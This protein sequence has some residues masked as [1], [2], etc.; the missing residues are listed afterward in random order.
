MNYSRF[1]RF[2]RLNS[3]PVPPAR[4]TVDD[5]QPI[6]E[7]TA[8]LFSLIIFQW[9]TP[10]L[11]LGYNRPLEASDLYELQDHRKSAYIGAKILASFERREKE[12]RKYNEALEKGEISPGWRALWW[13][14]RGNKAQ[15]L[16][17]WRE[18]DGKKR[19]SLTLAM[20][21][22]VKFFFWSAGFFKVLG[23]TA[24]IT[25]PLLVKV[26]DSLNSFLT[27]YLSFS[28]GNRQFCYRV[29]RQ[30]SNGTTYP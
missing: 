25:S 3:K 14:L 26:S 13:T 27:S 30:S 19:A 8:S 24:Q 6:P 16:K 7:T 28:I 23:D 22:S 15:R 21:D 12:A 20:N 10:L 29:F 9:I 5:A 4:G 2:F 1:R 17:Q 18:K 11:T